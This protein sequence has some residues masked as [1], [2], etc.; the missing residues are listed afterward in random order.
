[1][2]FYHKLI[3]IYLPA[4]LLVLLSCCT[5]EKAFKDDIRGKWKLVNLTMAEKML[6][7]TPEKDYTIHFK[8]DTSYELSL[9]V[10]QCFGD[11]KLDKNGEITL[12]PAGCTM[13]CCDSDFALKWT[14]LL[15]KMEYFSLT[16]NNLVLRGS[17]Q[18]DS[19]GKIVLE[20]L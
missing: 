9:D 2:V 13:V 3:Q 20:K 17:R 12:G 7:Q 10:N 1:M 5:E 14:R 11:Y 8:N 19:N 18:I 15:R 4:L 6:P 16:G